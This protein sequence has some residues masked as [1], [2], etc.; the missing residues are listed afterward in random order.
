[1][2]IGKRYPLSWIGP[3]GTPSP[4]IYLFIWLY[5]AKDNINWTQFKILADTIVSSLKASQGQKPIRISSVAFGGR[6]LECFSD[7]HSIG[8]LPSISTAPGEYQARLSHEVLQNYYMNC[9]VVYIDDRRNE[10]TFLTWLDQIISKLV[11]FN[12]RLKLSKCYFGM[13][14]IEFMGHI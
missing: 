14:H 11:E 6:K 4:S 3:V 2:Y 10:E 8:C 1:M 13:D 5:L 9:S 12:V 7:Y